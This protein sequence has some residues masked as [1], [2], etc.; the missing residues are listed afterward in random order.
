MVGVTSSWIS[1]VSSTARCVS[2]GFCADGSG[3]EG[4]SASSGL[5]SGGGDGEW[6]GVIGVVGIWLVGV[7][8]LTCGGEYSGSLENRLS[9]T[10][11][12]SSKFS[13]ST[14]LVGLLAN[15]GCGMSARIKNEVGIVTT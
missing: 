12:I 10:R 15:G 14:S 8:S 3:A 1:W 13:S 6:S 4:S 7:G 2:R 5:G 9:I 11:L